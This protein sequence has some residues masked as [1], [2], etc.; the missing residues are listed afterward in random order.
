MFSFIFPAQVSVTAA[1]ACNGIALA[2]QYD[3]GQV[4]KS[5]LGQQ[6]VTMKIAEAQ[7]I[8]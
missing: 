7:C 4:R 1:I 8:H 2:E 6:F 5:I 3:G